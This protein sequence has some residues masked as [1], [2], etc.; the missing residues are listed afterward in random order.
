MQPVQPSILLYCDREPPTQE[1]TDYF[2][3]FNII[4]KHHQS[5][6]SLPEKPSVLFAILMTDHLMIKDEA[7][8]ILDTLFHKFCAPIILLQENLDE[9]KCIQA[10]EQG[11]D[12]CI[13]K[14]IHVRELDARITAINRR[15]D[16]NHGL[17]VCKK[18]ECFSFYTWKFYPASRQIFNCQQEELKLS[19]SEYDLL[20]VFLKQS[21]TILSRKYLL[22]MMGLTVLDNPSDK[23]IELQISRLRH[24]IEPNSKKPTLIKTL[25]KIGYIFIG[26]VVTSFED[27]R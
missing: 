16:K 1:L 3:Q 7:C 21:Q 22:Q 17:V 6:Y 5:I 23:R 11:V 8:L 20:T 18:R 26:E 24:K 14:P 27:I 15:V 9:E 13:T 2:S 12:D 25:R 4:I 10:L 19:N